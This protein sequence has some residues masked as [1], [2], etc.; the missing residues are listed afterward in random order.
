MLCGEA[1]LKGSE[2]NIDT[3]HIV[4]PNESGFEYEHGELRITTDCGSMWGAGKTCSNLVLFP[5]LLREAVVETGFHLLPQFDGEQAGIVLFIDS[6]NYIKLVRERVA[7]QQVVV[8]AKEIDGRPSPESI[9]PFEGADMN[10]KLSIRGDS[11]LAR[12]KSTEMNEAQN[13][14]F[15][16]WFK[17]DAEFQVGLLVHG[18]NP[19]NKSI[20]HFLKINGQNL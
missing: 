4:N 12:W 10:L 20:F 3:A 11:I 1:C 5:A 18:D 2:M 13:S 17:R 14:E 16:N 15:T 7:G 8:L 9:R 6:D 19:K